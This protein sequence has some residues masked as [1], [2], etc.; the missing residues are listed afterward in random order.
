MNFWHHIVEV[1]LSWG[2]YG[3]LLVAALDSVGLPIIGGVDT[4]LVAIAT[5]KPHQAY[6][7][8]VCA[9]AGSL[10]GSL[11][12]FRI[13]RK[14]GEVLLEKHIS[15]RRGARLHTWFQRYGMITVFVPAV[16]PLP[17]PMKIPV[18]CAGALDV[19][20]SYFIFVVLSARVIR[21]FALAYFGVRYGAY[22][23]KFLLKH[24]LLIGLV[25]LGVAVAVAVA[26]RLYQR[27][28]V[29]AGEPE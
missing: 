19:R 21:Y 18:F 13:A 26:L 28:R 29:A 8:A 17:L 25:A 24:G 27:Y 9:I 12:L 2:P 10:A 15:G 11:I 6:L 22:T 23:G 3:L 7:S 1:L 16:S 5:N 4:L 14:G 20:L